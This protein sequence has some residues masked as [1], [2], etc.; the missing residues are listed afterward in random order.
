MPLYPGQPV[1]QNET[2]QKQVTD[3]MILTDVE[4][5]D[6]ASAMT[7]KMRSIKAVAEAFDKEFVE[8]SEEVATM[9]VKVLHENYIYL[10]C[11]LCDLIFEAERM[12]NKLHDALNERLDTV[13][14]CESTDKQ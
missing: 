3:K 1:P 13:N 5:S 12:S 10:F 11:V 9:N 14:H 7:T 2:T 6:I 4:L 8:P